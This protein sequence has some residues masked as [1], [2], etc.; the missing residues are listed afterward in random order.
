MP[1]RQPNEGNSELLTQGKSTT[2]THLSTNIIVLV[3]GK[4]IGAVQ[5]I[6]YDEGR[7]VKSIS[8]VGTD[9]IIDSAPQSSVE[10]TGNCDR[11]RF[12]GKRIAEAFGRGYLHL[13][14]QR[15]PFDIEI[16]D[17]F[18]GA[19]ATTNIVTTLHNCWLTKLGASYTSTDF[20]IVDSMSF[21]AEYISSTRNG[22]SAVSDSSAVVI[23]PF[24]QSADIGTYRGALDAPG[25]LKAFDG[26]GG[27]NL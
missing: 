20:V 23:N 6:S 7:A 25:L 18:S 27:W 10:I 21:K 1:I 17:Q 2:K 13:A 9:G 3:N 15:L 16:M 26:P 5:K 19:D 24:E 8:E 22:A 4:A 11:T 12:D 14:A